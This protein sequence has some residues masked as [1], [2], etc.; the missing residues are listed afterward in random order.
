MS[1]AQSPHAAEARFT[2]RFARTSAVIGIV[3]KDPVVF[4]S[5]VDAFEA[6]DGVLFKHLLA[7][8]R[9]GDACEEISGWLESKECVLECLRLC[10]PPSQEPLTVEQIARFADVVSNLSKDEFLTRRLVD[11]VEDWDSVGFKAVVSELGAEQFCHLLCHWVCV[12][13][14]RLISEVVCGEQKCADKVV[15]ELDRAGAAIRQ[16]TEKNV[17]LR[18]VIEAAVAPDPVAL[19]VAP[20]ALAVS[21]LAKLTAPTAMALAPLALAAYPVAVAVKPLALA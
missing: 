10:G 6:G 21:P 20:K 4:R 17:L 9:V 5:V 13:R 2:N 16:L 19:A 3:A 11:A 8:L 1:K 12:V 15:A 14:Y 7:Q 18:A